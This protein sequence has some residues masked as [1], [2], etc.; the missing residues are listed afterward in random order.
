MRKVLID[1]EEFVPLAE[2]ELRPTVKQIV[3]LQRGWVVIGEVSRDGEDVTISEASVIRRWGTTRG[4]GELALEGPKANTVL[5]PAG[6]VRGHALGIVMTID[7]DES[8]W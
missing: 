1:G 6:T 8:K 2:I 7:V 4:L 5:D 3:V